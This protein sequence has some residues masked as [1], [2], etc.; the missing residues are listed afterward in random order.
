MSSP[1][2]SGAL[3]RI[4]PALRPHLPSLVDRTVARIFESIAFYRDTPGVRDEFHTIVRDNFD[5]LLDHAPGHDDQATG[6]PPE[7]TGRRHAELGAPLPD[8]LAAYR[9]GFALLWDTITTV[10]ETDAV[11][12]GPVIEAAT[13]MFWRADHFGQAVTE[14]YRDTT[15]EILLRQEH[16]R[17]AMVEALITA[18][19]VEQPALRET[20]SRLGIP[21]SGNFLVAVAAAEPLGGEPLPGIVAS[22]RKIAAVSAWRLT[23][24]QTVGIVSLPEPDP[25]GAI[26]SIWAHSTGHVGVSPLFTHLDTTPRAFYLA[27]VALRSRPRPEARVRRFEDTPVAALVAAAPDAAAEIARTVLGPVLELPE[28]DRNTL[29]NT[30]ET[31]MQR[32]G[33]VAKTA[34]ELYLHPNTVRYR[35]RKLAEYTG[36]STENPIATGELNT[37]LLAWRLAGDERQ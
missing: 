1:P 5:Y 37:A 16:E 19:I 10:L 6:S 18:T 26:E 34:A 33:S 11:G 4:A 15:T 14:G 36:R 17:S 29:L 21:C 3:T 27:G 8:V 23:P 12:T 28:H 24:H 9:V 20:A 31:W 35:L 7:Q 25:T 13:E 2:T 30:F 32:D 22:L